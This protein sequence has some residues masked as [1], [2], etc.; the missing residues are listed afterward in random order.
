MLEFGGTNLLQYIYNKLSEYFRSINIISNS[1]FEKSFNC[2]VYPDI[3]NS[4]GPVSGI[5]SALVRSDSEFCFV[6]PADMPFFNIPAITY[7]IS[8]LND[9]DGA[10]FSENGR[11]QPLFGFYRKSLIEYIESFEIIPKSDSNKVNFKL[12]M[13]I[14]HNKFNII[15][16]ADKEFYHQNF[17]FNINTKEDY[18]SA[19]ELI[20]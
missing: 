6:C 19:L 14:N 12:K 18:L 10:I 5:H 9:Y 15:E 16:I 2:N 3:I 7:L 17:F 11:L 4:V 1:E 8:N 20:K 13:M